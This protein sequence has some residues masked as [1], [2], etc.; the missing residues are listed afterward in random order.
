MSVLVVITSV[1]KPELEEWIKHGGIHSTF[2]SSERLYQT[3]AT[4]HSLR[5]QLPEAQLLLVD[6][7]IPDYRSQLCQAVPELTYLHLETL[8]PKA[9]AAV[10][11]SGSKSVGEC[12]LML[13]AWQFQQELFLNT[14]FVLKA[15]GRYLFEN[16][17][18][19]AFEQYDLGSY[20]FPPHDPS[21][22]R[23]WQ[24]DQGRDL[25]LATRRR[26]RPLARIV[27]PT[28]LYGWGHYQTLDHF[29]RLERI[30]QDLYRPEYYIYDI[31]NLLARELEGEP[32]FC[33]DWHYFGWN[34]ESG[35]FLRR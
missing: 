24:D 11:S 9:A 12:Q 16:L 4:L 8:D 22:I 30:M 25:Y 17:R 7:S 31:E 15:S 2:T 32:V 10:R 26:P 3:I 18:P 23:S 6:G 13:S 33:T 35:V 28:V 27:L 5:L 19:Q 1:I 20:L 29:V 34:G 21:D 14:D